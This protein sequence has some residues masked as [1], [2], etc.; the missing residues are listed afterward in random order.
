MCCQEWCQVPIGVDAARWVT[1]RSSRTVLVVVHTVTSGQRL[2]DVVRLLEGDLRVQVVFT[3][4][5]DVFNNGVP[6]FLRR[7]G[8][9]VLPWR[10]ATQHR[11]D[12]AVAAA[13]G[14]IEDIHAPLVV[15]PH[16]AGFN[17]RV[18]RRLTG[19]AGA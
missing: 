15:V 12:L 13:Y 2:L 17:K 4:G 11:F 18:G 14:G 6:E 7:V 16:G 10:Q 19:G 3:T 8:G 9:V 5:P 1:R